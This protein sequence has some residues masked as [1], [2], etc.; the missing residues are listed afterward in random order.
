MPISVTA[1]GSLVYVVNAGGSGNISGFWLS[2]GGDLTAIDGST[3]PLSGA[4]TGP[5][6]VEFTPAGDQLV[7]TEKNTNLILTYAVE[8]G[9]LTT[10]PTAHPS[11]G[12]TPFGFAFT[13][14]D[15]LVVSE[16]FGGAPDASAT[17]SYRLD[18]AG[19]ELVSGSIGTT[20]T[21]AC[22]TVVTNNGKFAYVT[23]TGSG[24]VTGYRV[25]NDGTLTLLDDDGA[26]GS[27][28]AG[29]TPIDAAFSGN[30]HFLYV[31][32]AGNGGISAF[33]VA[34]NGSLTSIDN[35]SGLPSG[36]VGIAAR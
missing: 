15:L 33:R 19:L 20:E 21:A 30:A 28:G 1:H 31:L 6:Q 11:S 32:T 10:G 23:N 17:S 25:A 3:R 36:S 29:S 12:I 16:A 34:K 26:T 27:T 9:G 13:R 2:A 22:W 18:G 7:V 4:G 35:A 24:T 8:P 14:G 5:A